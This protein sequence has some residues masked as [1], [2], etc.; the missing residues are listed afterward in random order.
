MSSLSGLRNGDESGEAI[1]YD[2]SPLFN[3]NNKTGVI[4]VPTLRITKV[5]D[6]SIEFGPIRLDPAKIYHGTVLGTIQGMEALKNEGIPIEEL[7]SFLVAYD[8]FLSYSSSY[9]PAISSSIGILHMCQYINEPSS[10]DHF[11]IKQIIDKIRI[12]T[13][14]PLIKHN[15]MIKEK[16]FKPN[17]PIN[18]MNE[19]MISILSINSELSILLELLRIK[20]NARYNFH[21]IGCDI[22]VEG[23]KIHEVEISRRIQRVSIETFRVWAKESRVLDQDKV[24]ITLRGLTV[25]ISIEIANKL[26]EELRQG[27]IIILDLS[28]TMDGNILAALRHFSSDGSLLSFRYAFTEAKKIASQGKKAVIFFT[29]G[30]GALSQEESATSAFSYPADNILRFLKDADIKALKQLKNLDIYSFIGL[31]STVLK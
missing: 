11:S 17:D 13:V 5:S 25:S 4:N 19:L 10:V 6:K 8:V 2:F 21:G 16:R 30:W 31:Y 1:S 3:L 29:N 14:R 12:K 9:W 28:S 18:F 23:I 22:F 26:E 20:E 24:N 7:S 27:N 15:K